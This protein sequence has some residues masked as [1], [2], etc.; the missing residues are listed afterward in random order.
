MTGPGNSK[1]AEAI[2]DGRIM[3]D[4]LDDLAYRKKAS[5]N[6]IKAY[7]SDLKTFTD[8]LA[9]ECG[10]GFSQCDKSD[11][12]Q[13][14]ADCRERHE[15][16]RTIKR[17]VACLGGFFAWLK[18]RG[19]I[20]K[21]PVQGISISGTVRKIPEVL[22]E[23]EMGKL[24]E[25]GRK[26]SVTLRRAGILL[27]L[28]Y[29]TGMRISESVSLRIENLFL[30]EGLVRIE[31]GKGEKGRIV[32]VPRQTVD[33]LNFYLSEIRPLILAGERSSYV[34]VTRSGGK[35]SR[36]A[37][38]RDIKKLGRIA[39]IKG[40]LYPHILR[41]TCATHLLENGC[42]LRTVQI[43]LGHSDLSVTEIYTHV[44][45]ERKR[46]VFKNAHPRA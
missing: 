34:F 41:H 19:R 21:S 37:A 10:K 40:N 17:R 32:I 20:E 13:F 30:D 29:A 18:N 11:L 8:F 45:E 26:G 1:L 27:E 42:D 44:L 7:E 16:S 22:T 46:K 15:S 23:S 2:V 28:M 6:T 38:W 3:A 33:R 4:Y 12:E 36:Q 31:S 5:P 35:F 25:A 43:L 9:R 14:I 39:G 24:L